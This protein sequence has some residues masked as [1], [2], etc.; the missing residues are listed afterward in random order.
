MAI[1][2]SIMDYMSGLTGFVFD[3]SVLKRIAFERGVAD[4]VSYDE[5]TERD[6]DL[7]LADLLMAA[8]HSGHNLPSFQHQHGQFSMSIGQQ[9]I[10]D[11]DSLLAEA[12]RL[13]RK[14][15][16]DVDVLPTSS[17]QWMC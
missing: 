12:R 14:W 1:A 15:D 17:L 10:K 13:Y 2:F 9:V 5:L 7:I 4:V 3:E 11:R 16:E 6:K 8:Y